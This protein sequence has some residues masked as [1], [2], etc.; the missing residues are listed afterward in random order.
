[1]VLSETVNMCR[2]GLGKEEDSIGRLELD[3]VALRITTRQDNCACQIYLQN[4]TDTYTVYM[5][6]YNRLTAAAPNHSDCGL[7]INISVSDAIGKDKV[8]ERVECNNGTSFRPII[9]KKNEKL[10]FKSTII[11]GN[12]TK[13]YC[14]QIFRSKSKYKYVH[15]F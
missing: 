14:L 5:Q 15:I 1:M 7:V 6:K 9:L 10:N 11:E 4:Q 3:S 12:F 8:L 2:S 13:G